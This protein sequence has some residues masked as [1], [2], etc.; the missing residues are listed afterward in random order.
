MTKTKQHFLQNIK[1]RHPKL[2]DKK[3]KRKKYFFI[4]ILIIF[5]SSINVGTVFAQLSAI[6]TG[7]AVIVGESTSTC[8]GTI[9]GAIRYNSTTSV[10]EF[11]DA[12][13]WQQW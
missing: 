1:T 6:F 9:E 10:I 7:G 5:L 2:T 12:S 4:A 8:D 13:S 3:Y 11:C